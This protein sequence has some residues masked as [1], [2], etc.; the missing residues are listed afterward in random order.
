MGPGSQDDA[1]GG[2]VV[3]KSQF[4]KVNGYIE[5]GKSEGAKVAYGGDRWKGKG[6]FIEPTSKSL[7]SPMLGLI[8]RPT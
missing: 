4:D 2:P 3:S 5:S 6:F 7:N 1:A 8:H